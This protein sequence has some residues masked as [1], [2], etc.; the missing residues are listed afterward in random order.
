M[1]YE[2]YILLLQGVCTAG[3][4]AAGAMLQNRRDASVTVNDLR[5]ERMEW[6]DVAESGG[7]GQSPRAHRA[8]LLPDAADT[9][10]DGRADRQE[11]HQS[12]GRLDRRLLALV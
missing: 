3:Y 10:V 8:H 11:I 2:I 4:G 7:V 6:S 1:L 9:D 5:A 12:Q